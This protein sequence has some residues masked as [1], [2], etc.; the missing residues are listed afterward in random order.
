MSTVRA[1]VVGIERYAYPGAN[2]V[3]PAQAALAV[4]RWLLSLPETWPDITLRL[5]LFIDAEQ[6]LDA[7][8]TAL[9]QRGGVTVHRQTDWQALDDF[10]R[11]ELALGMPPRTR[12]FVF[13]SGHGFTTDFDDNRLFLCSDYSQAKPNRVFNGSNFLR[14]LRTAAFSCFDNQ[15]MLADVCGAY[16]ETPIFS[17]ERH[18]QRR[19][20][21]LVYFATP[22][23][24]YARSARAGG[25][26]TE[27]A[28]EVLQAL[29][30]DWSDR[31]RLHAALEAAFSSGGIAPLKLD[32]WS[33]LQ[34]FDDD[35][36]RAPARDLAL[37]AL[38]L[39]QQKD[40]TAPAFW[41]R[42]YERVVAELGLPDLNRQTQLASALHE[43]AQL[44]D[45]NPAAQRLPHGL[46][47][48]MLRLA[49]EPD[50]SGAIEAWLLQ[51]APGQQR[52]CDA[53]RAELALERR[54]RLLLIDVAHDRGEITGFTPY[55]CLADGRLD[56]D[57]RLEAAVT[58]DWDAF[59]A[60]LQ[61][62]LAQLSPGGSLNN[63]QIHFVVDTPLLDRAF[64]RIPLSPG[65][66]AIGEEA[67]VLLRY[68]SRVYP[69]DRSLRDKWVGYAKALRKV[70]P[71]DLEWL[72]I[73]NDATPLPVRQG[74]CF[75]A[76]SLPE[77][78]P[79]SAGAARCE[80][81]KQVLYRLL[82]L[83]APILYFSHANPAPQTW[84]DVA[85][86]LN[87]RTRPLPQLDGFIECFRD[88]RLSGASYAN[89]AT[90]LWDDP[91]MTPFQPTRGASDA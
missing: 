2:V 70:P 10:V 54:E 26:F 59:V 20:P 42:P 67:V 23:G 27:T 7:P 81:E 28:L 35:A 62:L 4:A 53:I 9:L 18:K 78:P 31:A 33:E 22:D 61:Q 21:Q 48:F 69:R 76:F 49:Q 88:D 39:L 86:T 40:I 17:F 71:T 25:V 1:F 63:L 30:A 55:L 57:Q 37:S 87:G 60:A 36:A 73:E 14:L 13:W 16:R 74:P 24:E 41:R 44:L 58:P 43:L 65:G 82:R 56:D 77:P 68:R 8:T 38:E 66:L 52:S 34:A 79:G 5:D 19:Q 90:L 51:Q 32:G 64:H 84:D 46:L 80:R 85:A 75:A 89:Q 83:G 12:L 45:G 11:D 91:G 15:I 47:V 29:Q 72:R 6:V 3:G 50:L